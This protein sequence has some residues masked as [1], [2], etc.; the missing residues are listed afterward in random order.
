MAC[1][2]VELIG[3]VPADA[4]LISSDT[5]P[6]N[7]WNAAYDRILADFAEDDYVD[8]EYFVTGDSEG[9]PQ[10]YVCSYS[11]ISDAA[12]CYSFADCEEWKEPYSKAA[13]GTIL[14]VGLAAGAVLIYVAAKA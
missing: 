5:V 9:N 11:N 13:I 6:N 7:I 3:D 12:M 4:M 8:V 14:A 1:R 10:Y 2:A